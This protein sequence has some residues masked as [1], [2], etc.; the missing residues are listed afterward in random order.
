MP[1]KPRSEE[2]ESV[3]KS[4]Q[5]VTIDLSTGARIDYAVWEDARN[6]LLAQPELTRTIP[7]WIVKNRW[8]GQFW[9][10]IKAQSDTYA[11]RREFIWSSIAP[12][13]DVIRKGATLPTARSL[14]PLLDVCSSGDVS[15]A[16]AR[17]QTRK[18]SDPEGTITAARALLE[19]TCKYILDQLRVEY[20][21]ADDLPKLYGQVAAAMKLGPQDHNEQVFKQVL[22]GCFSVVNGMAAIRNT[23]GDAHGKGRRTPRP[24]LR[25]ATLA[26]NLG[27]AIATFLIATYEER[28][29]ARPDAPRSG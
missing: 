1:R 17:I 9:Q 8:G 12:L 29:K 24:A 21:D 20:G 11:G 4:F 5:E 2:L 28:Y 25:H 14:E 26:A 7:E 23:L 10:F 19:S 3:V 18:G 15:D 16:W 27:G 22:S 13:F 6:A